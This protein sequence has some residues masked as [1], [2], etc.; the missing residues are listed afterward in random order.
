MGGVV[1]YECGSAMHAQGRS[2]ETIIMVDPA[3][4]TLPESEILRRQSP[5]NG[6]NCAESNEFMWQRFLNFK[7]DSETVRELLTEHDFFAKSDAERFQLVEKHQKRWTTNIL[8]PLGVRAS[9]RFMSASYS[10]LQAYV[11]SRY[12]GPIHVI[13]SDAYRSATSLNWLRERAEVTHFV[14][15]QGDHLTA[16]LHFAIP[17]IVEIISRTPPR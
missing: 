4:Q 15:V 2:A 5:D 9:F 8:K 3:P 16:I 11:P 13:C 6:L 17:D 14:R 10:A 1:A 12:P 7:C